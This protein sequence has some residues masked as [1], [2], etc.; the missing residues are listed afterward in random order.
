[1]HSLLVQLCSDIF[2]RRLIKDKSCG[3]HVTYAS[4]TKLRPGRSQL[5]I[6]VIN[7][8]PKCKYLLPILTAPRDG[9]SNPSGGYKFVKKVNV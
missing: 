5:N 1:M 9:G 3:N 4:S 7:Y 2:N 6:T 8:P